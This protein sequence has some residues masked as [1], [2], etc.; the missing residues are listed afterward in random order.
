M[1]TLTE[2]ATGSLQPFVETDFSA[3]GL[4]PGCGNMNYVT[5]GSCTGGPMRLCF[6]PSLDGRRSMMACEQFGLPTEMEYGLADGGRGSDAGNREDDDLEASK[7]PSK[8]TKKVAGRMASE[9][10]LALYF[11]SNGEHIV[12]PP[13][14]LCKGNY[15]YTHKQFSVTVVKLQGCEGDFRQLGHYDGVT[16]SGY[17]AWPFLFLNLS[18]ST[19]DV[20]MLLY[21]G[22]PSAPRP[23][24]QAFCTPRAHQRQWLQ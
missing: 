7:Q 14:L 11:C 10:T 2:T 1:N 24:P 12:E 23:V 20:R 18:P 3:T 4:M 6:D 15:H 9:V 8:E 21:L 19:A 22:T 5:D 13:Q 17:E 16:T